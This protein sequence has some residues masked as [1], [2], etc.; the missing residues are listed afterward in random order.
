FY[1]SFCTS[2]GKAGFRISDNVHSHAEFAPHIRD[3]QPHACGYRAHLLECL[4]RV[5]L[6]SMFIPYD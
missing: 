6:F 4:R 5:M 3:I 2:L 1:G